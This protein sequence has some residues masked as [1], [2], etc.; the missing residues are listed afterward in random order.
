ML[1]YSYYLYQYLKYRVFCQVMEAFLF[2]SDSEI[3]TNY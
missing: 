3:T 2:P 1:I